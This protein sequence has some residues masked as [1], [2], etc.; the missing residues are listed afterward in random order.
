MTQHEI[1]KKYILGLS[2]GLENSLVVVSPAGLGKT[3]TTMKTL[4]ELGYQE[5]THFKYIQNYITPL[6]LF[7]LL[8]EVNKLQEPRIL[9]ID[10]GEDTLSN[11]RAVGLLRGALWGFGGQR[12]VGWRSGTYKIKEKEFNFTGKIIFLLNKLN[13]KN[14]VVNALKDRSLFFELHLTISDMFSLIRQRAELPYQDIPINK[15]KEIAEFLIGV[16][17]NSNNIS[18]RALP[19]AFNLFLLSP[20]HYKE[21]I[22][23]IL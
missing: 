11:P 14:P 3:E 6:E 22:F 23:Q 5:N 18:L 4:E 19:R 10:D 21:L 15:R 13:T 7:L 12:K 9:V 1:L 16:G 2:K 20:N 17:K 8:Q